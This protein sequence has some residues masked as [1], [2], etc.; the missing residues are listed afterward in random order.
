MTHQIIK[1]LRLNKGDPQLYAIFSGGVGRWFRWDMSAEQV[2]VYYSHRAAVDTERSIREQLSEIEIDPKRVYA[3]SALSFEEANVDSV[4]AGGEDLI[5]CG[6]EIGHAPVTKTGLGPT[7]QVIR[8]QQY[9]GHG[10]EIPHSGSANWM[11]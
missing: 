10:P 2:I 5:H 11:E 3:Q 4:A 1:Q 7:T 6:R 9:R 8:C